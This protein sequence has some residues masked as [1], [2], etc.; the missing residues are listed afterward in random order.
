M[1]DEEI[2]VS[3]DGCNDT[4]GF[5]CKYYS[6]DIFPVGWCKK[7]DHPLQPPGRK[8]K[9]RRLHFKYFFCTVVSSHILHVIVVT[10]ISKKGRPRL[11]S[12]IT[13]ANENVSHSGTNNED[14]A[15]SS[16]SPRVTLIEADTSTMPSKSENQSKI[17]RPR[18]L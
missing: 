12:P 6:R 9:T 8:S 5:N 4:Y 10:V 1:N 2:F 16:A 13:M 17:H 15:V 18:S 3:F 14:I 7:S 11:R